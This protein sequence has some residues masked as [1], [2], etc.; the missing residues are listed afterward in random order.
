MTASYKEITTRSN[1]KIYIFDDLFEYPWREQAH[2]FCLNSHYKLGWHDSRILER[3][4][5]R[6][7][8]CILSQEDLAAFG[9][10][11]QLSETSDDRLKELLNGKTARLANISLSTATETY[12][13]HFDDTKLT[14]LYY[15]NIEW[16]HY[17]GGETMF[18]ED[19]GTEIA[20]A[21]NF[22][23][24]RLILFDGK[25]PHAARPQTMSA[26]HYRFSFV[27]FLV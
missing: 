19:P 27:M 6:Y 5:D 10:V 20:Y 8:H 9:I 14:L 12:Y 18:Y 13:P 4:Q 15:V 7:L 2:Q 3:S 1:R 16:N 11:N 21:S 17:W 26:P 25:I 22:V 24:G 23:P